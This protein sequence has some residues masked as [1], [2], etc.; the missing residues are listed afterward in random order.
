MFL[1]LKFYG[2]A[3]F[4]GYTCYHW[5]HIF[6]GFAAN[7]PTAHV[8]KRA[9]PLV[10]YLQGAT[11][12]FETVPGNLYG[13]VFNLLMHPLVILSGFDRQLLMSK[14]IGLSIIALVVIAAVTFFHYVKTFRVADK[15][16][17][18]CL[19]LNFNP[20]IYD[21]QTA[22]PEL[23]ELALILLGI[24]CYQRKHFSW[25]GFSLAAA[26][27]IKVYPFFILAGFLLFKK[28][29]L[30][31]G[32]FHAFWLVTLTQW[33]Y[34]SVMGAGYF[35]N[36]FQRI[37][38]GASNALMNYGVLMWDNLSMKS[39]WIK[40]ISGFESTPEGVV[41]ID[42]PS[43]ISLVNSLYLG[44]LLALSS[45]A[46]FFRSALRKL[47][48]R[49]AQFRDHFFVS[50]ICLAVLLLGPHAS[51]ES[52]VLSLP[53]FILALEY[54]NSVWRQKKMISMIGFY[55]VVT[56]MIIPF[57][58]F[59]SL[60]QFNQ[61]AMTIL[62]QLSTRAPYEIYRFLGMPNLGLMV[63]ALFWLGLARERIR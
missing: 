34:G 19:L 6:A 10:Q 25:A 63:L 27:L 62:P 5:Y 20:L 22:S 28:R 58:M 2:I 42:N 33:L 41:M 24:A 53:A 29:V 37:H 8:V 32:I 11:P 44:V 47:W 17:I 26:G 50:M 54:I 43:I 18:V 38:P 1:N 60:T 35:I 14:T 23:W 48:I 9:M 40:W 52:L 21:F 45:L 3:A 61:I 30:A 55:L 36:L 16:I 15:I 39:M 13:P 12:E 46:I 49:E 51:T 56:G 4:L 59:L 7:I 31:W 57:S